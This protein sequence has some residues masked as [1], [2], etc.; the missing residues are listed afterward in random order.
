MDSPRP[1][2]PPEK[3]KVGSS[4]LPLATGDRAKG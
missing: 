2:K 3:R 4:D 1:A